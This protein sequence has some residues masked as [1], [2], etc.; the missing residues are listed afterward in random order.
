MRAES[1]I[2]LHKVSLVGVGV[3]EEGVTGDG[4]WN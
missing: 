2:S 3:G 4:F 1:R